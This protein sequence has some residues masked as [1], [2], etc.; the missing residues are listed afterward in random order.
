MIIKNDKE[1]GIKMILLNYTEKQ[2]VSI[3]KQNKLVHI[4]IKC[5]KSLSRD[6]YGKW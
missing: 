2:V 1:V 6:K 4:E 3:N 5:I